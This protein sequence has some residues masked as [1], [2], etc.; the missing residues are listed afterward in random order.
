MSEPSETQLIG[1]LKLGD[2]KAARGLWELYFKRLVGLARAKLAGVRGR[3]AAAEDVALSAFK[4]LCM[5]A[6][7]GRFPELCSRD[8][9]WPLLLVITSRKASKLI[10]YERRKKRGGGKVLADADLAGD[11]DLSPLEELISQEP[12]PEFSMAMAEQ[13]DYLLGLLDDSTRVVALAKMEGLTNDEIAKMN[14]TALRTVERKL[15]LIRRIWEKEAA[16]VG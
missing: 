10:A 5:G 7:R 2:D 3:D 8:N 12:T 6:R 13:C 11:G 9:L 1:N 14:G 15:Q 4:S 16:G